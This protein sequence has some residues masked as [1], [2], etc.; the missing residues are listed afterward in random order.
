MNTLS[1][2]GVALSMMERSSEPAQ[3]SSFLFVVFE[4]N[5]TSLT[6]GLIFC[7]RT[8]SV[9]FATTYTQGKHGVICAAAVEMVFTWFLLHF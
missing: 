9:H 5:P 4:I 3:S 2:L 6:S 1:P 8:N 7:G